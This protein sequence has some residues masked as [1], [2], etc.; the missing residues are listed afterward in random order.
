MFYPEVLNYSVAILAVAG[1]TPAVNHTFLLFFSEKYL[2]AFYINV[3]L[4]FLIFLEVLF[5]FSTLILI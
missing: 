4:T 5:R 2:V 3:S 1:K